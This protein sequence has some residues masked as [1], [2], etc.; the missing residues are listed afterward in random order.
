MVK[1]HNASL[2]A[3]LLPGL[4]PVR[5]ARGIRSARCGSTPTLKLAER[6]PVVHNLVVSN[7]PGPPVPL[8][9]LGARIA[10]MYPL[11]PIFHGAGLNVTV[12]SIDGKLNVGLMSC[13]ELAPELWDLADAFG[14][15]LDE[16]VK[17][18]R[19]KTRKRKAT[20]ART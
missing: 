9:L 4:V 10:A 12:M 7:V 8:Y 13:P 1:S 20:P 16:M 2:G 18:A 6:H 19:A 11:G 17:A 14:P 5:R 15:A 3:S